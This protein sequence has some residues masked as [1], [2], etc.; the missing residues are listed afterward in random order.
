MKGATTLLHRLVARPHG[1][2][3]GQSMRFILMSVSV[4]TVCACDVPKKEKSTSEPPP[5][6]IVMLADD[7]GMGDTSAYQD[8]TG[9][10]DTAQVYT[11]GMERLARIGVRMSDAHST[12]TRCSPTRY[13][14]M[15]GRYPW[16]NR[17][18]Q[19]VLARPQ[20]DP[21]IEAD[22]PTIASML[23][24][25]GY[26]T[27]LIG[28]WHI[29]LRYRR[30]DSGPAAGWTDADLTQP[31]HTTPLDHGFDV[32][33]YL[34]RS[35]LSAGPRLA[36]ATDMYG[37]PEDR[38]STDQATGPGHIHG[39]RILAASGDGKRLIEEGP[40]AYVLERLG[41]R[42]S[43]GAMDVLQ[44]HIEDADQRARPFFLY[45]ASPSN[46]APYTPSESI[47]GRAVKGAARSVAGAP[48]G[49]RSDYIFE[50]DL[51]LN[52]FIDWLATTDDPRRPGRPLL[53]NTLIVFT[54]DNGAEINDKTATGPFRSNKGSVFEGGH[55]TP[56]LV[57]W[58]LGGVGDGSDETPGATRDGLIAT[59]DLYATFA[60]VVGAAMPDVRSG[61]K[62]GE[63]STDILPVLRGDE[64]PHPYPPLFH[65]DHKEHDERVVAAV[66]V[67]D[68][69]ID[70]ETI[71][72]HWKL[73]VSPELLRSG[74]AEPEALYELV[75]DQMEERNRLDESDLAPLVAHM[76]ALAELHRNVGGHRLAALDL[77]TPVT[78]AFTTGSTLQPQA[79]KTAT[80][81]VP[82]LIG[83][84]P[85]GLAVDPAALT[86]TGYGIGVA[87]GDSDVVDGGE[88]LELT[89]SAD[90]IVEHVAIVAGDGV[91]GGSYSVGDAA[92]LAIYCVD[93]DNDPRDQSGVLGDIGVVKAGEALRLDSSAH[94]GTEPPGRWRVKA[95]RVRPLN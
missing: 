44:S 29:G 7:M 9:N 72:G 61:E 1:A 65:N 43:D 6:I 77:G 75:G 76:S 34:S 40:D 20:G 82:A 69:V 71:A 78:F 91:C 68:P 32:A 28:K 18:K 23:G 67:N 45:F 81:I 54:S 63:D 37:R 84:A 56:F 60:G 38:N 62:G 42:F 87:G 48:M 85:D 5:N 88:A 11:P 39:R 36:T 30:S 8:L 24:E 59:H 80:D 25:Q 73:F 92:P 3:R 94:H 90:V 83:L 58:P 17:L 70:G 95:V 46:H 16:R 86:R 53:E 89:F 14:L 27:V 2:K 51:I 4:L 33:R 57:S 10:P 66:R 49:D 93:A 19:W 50:N 22:R 79:S 64:I 15:T 21:M 31:L 74:T 41:A 55:R 26:S 52:R 12:S 13:G 47:G 35:H